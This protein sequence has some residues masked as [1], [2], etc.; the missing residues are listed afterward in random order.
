MIDFL[1]GTITPKDWMTVGIVLSVTVVLVL[2]FALVIHADQLKTLESVTEEDATVYKQLEEARNIQRNIA[3]LRDE[4]QTYQELVADF[5][6]RLPFESEIAQLFS[7]FESMAAEV[8]I[9]ATVKP[10]NRTKDSSK[11][12]IPYEVTATGDFRQILDFVNRLER[13]K[14]F[15]KVT[16][17]AI[18]EEKEGVCDAKF[19]LNTF[20]FIQSPAEDKS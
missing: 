17:F 4:T 9:K 20:R 6:E 5:E 3:D 14:R 12:T 1:K 7:V 16:N 18:L 2:V 8:G 19:T 10:L 11:E 13:Y 15:L